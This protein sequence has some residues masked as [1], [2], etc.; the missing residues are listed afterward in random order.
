MVIYHCV[1][2]YSAF[3]N[4]PRDALIQMERDLLRRA[5]IVFASSAQLCA[6][7]RPL[8]P[9]S[10]FI[11][12]GVDVSHFAQAADPKTVVPDEL[13]HLPRPI[14][15]FIGLLADWVDLPLIRELALARPTW[16]LVLIGKSTTDLTPSEGS[17]TCTCSGKAYGALPGYC[18]GFTS[19]SFLSGKTI[20]PCV[21]TLKLR[22][23]LAAGLP[24][25]ATPLLVA[26]YTLSSDWLKGRTPS[27]PRKPRWMRH[28]TLLLSP[29]GSHAHESWDAR[30]RDRNRHRPPLQ[31]SR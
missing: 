25:V 27:P 30:R 8:N 28:P 24:V 23:Y 9:N 4:V 22:E 11:S 12:H 20:S 6:E 19:A 21:P 15:G 3:S 5:D 14:V 31:A 13:R 2:E 1:D 17:R 29:H 16:S 18:R 26:R 10:H 7:R